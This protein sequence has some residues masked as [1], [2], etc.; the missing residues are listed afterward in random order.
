LPKLS[1]DA[2]AS[3][4]AAGKPSEPVASVVRVHVSPPSELLAA[5]RPARSVVSSFAAVKTRSVF[6]GSTATVVSV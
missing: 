4:H 6:V 5:N 3:Q 1:Q 2:V